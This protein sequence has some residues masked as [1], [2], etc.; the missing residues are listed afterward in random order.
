MERPRAQQDSDQLRRRGLA[1]LVFGF[2]VCPCHLPFTLLAVGAVFGGTAVGAAIT[3]PLTAGVV[4]GAVTALA[5]V[6]GLR[7]VRR[8]DSCTSGACSAAVESAAPSRPALRR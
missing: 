7:L 1:W 2:A 4:L 8:A 6:N 5:Y 3:G